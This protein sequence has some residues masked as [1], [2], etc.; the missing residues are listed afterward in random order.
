MAITKKGTAWEVKKSLWIIWSFIFL[1]GGI[2]IGYAGR[3][4]RVNKWTKY[5]LLYTVVMLITVIIGS[6]TVGS[7]ID[8]I[9]MIIF[10]ISYIGCIVHSFK[11]R[12]EYLI[13]LE[14]MEIQKIDELET[15]NLR[16]KI[17]NEYGINNSKISTAKLSNTMSNKD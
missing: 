14:V 3:K 4:V 2:G 15:D 10:F 1:L 6:K 17:A 12:K 13:R 16:I 7:I 9:S 8:D 11:I 5:G